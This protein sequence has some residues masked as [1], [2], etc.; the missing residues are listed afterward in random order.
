MFGNVLMV[1]MALFLV[2]EA[3]R[4][5]RTGE[6]SVKNSV[7]RRV[8]GSVPFDMLV[9]GYLFFAA[10]VLDMTIG[11]GFLMKLINLKL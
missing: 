1:L 11:F 9:G 8:D 10:A 2:W 6:L 7:I 3:V 4:A 5:I